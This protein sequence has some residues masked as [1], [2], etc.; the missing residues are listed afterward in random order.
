LEIDPVHVG[1]V[2]GE[3]DATSTGVGYAMHG[4]EALSVTLT[5]P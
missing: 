2:C 4:T 5:W 1:A 3:R